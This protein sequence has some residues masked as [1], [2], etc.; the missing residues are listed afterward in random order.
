MF[1]L[2]LK[3]AD[4]DINEH[5]DKSLFQYDSKKIRKVANPPKTK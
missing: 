4:E 3:L 2:T 5:E 1:N